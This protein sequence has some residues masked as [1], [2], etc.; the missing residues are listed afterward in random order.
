MCYQLSAFRWLLLVHFE[1]NRKQEQPFR[2]CSSEE[3]RGGPH[4]DLLLLV[5]L[6]PASPSIHLNQSSEEMQ[7]RFNNPDP[8]ELAN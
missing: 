6:T 8:N 2:S 5:P 1:G 4:V 3:K 7:D